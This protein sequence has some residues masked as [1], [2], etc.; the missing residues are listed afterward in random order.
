MKKIFLIISCG[1]I[2]IFLASCATIMRDNYQA[3]PINAN[4]EKVNIKITDKTGSTVFEGQTP[5]TITLKTS[6]SGYFNPQKYTITA[7]KD[8]Y[9]TQTTVIDWHVSG[10]YYVGNLVFGGLLGYLIIDPIS[11]D[12]Y[13]LDDQVQLNMAQD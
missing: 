12:M 2:S 9:K 7:S 1:I 11:G 3:I 6:K 8:G 10:W 13:Y 4:T 5:T